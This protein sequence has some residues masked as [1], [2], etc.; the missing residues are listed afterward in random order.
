M[1]Y[2]S[3]APAIG[4]PKNYVDEHAELVLY[5]SDEEEAAEPPEEGTWEHW[6]EVR[7]PVE[8]VAPQSFPCLGCRALSGSS[9]SNLRLACTFSC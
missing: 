5:E 3:E 1:L 4:Q 8:P 9:L 7:C 2:E 6:E